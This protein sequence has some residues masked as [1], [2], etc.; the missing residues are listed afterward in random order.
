GPSPQPD[1]VCDDR[2]GRERETDGPPA[3]GRA[4]SPWRGGDPRYPGGSILAHHAPLGDL[5]ATLYS[6]FHARARC[7]GV[8]GSYFFSSLFPAGYRGTPPPVGERLYRAAPPGA[9]S[10]VR[11]GA[12]EADGAA[13]ACGGAGG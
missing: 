4:L 9:A 13:P 6:L 8:R 12:A 1:P 11:S 2:A 7:R 10:A 5:R 3:L